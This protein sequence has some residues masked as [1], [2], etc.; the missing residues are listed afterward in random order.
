MEGLSLK[1]SPFHDTEAQSPHAEKTPPVPFNFVGSRH[2]SLIPL[3][4]VTSVVSSE[5][6]GRVLPWI[7]V[8]S[9]VTR[10][11]VEGSSICANP[12]IYDHGACATMLP[13]R[14]PMA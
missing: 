9:A 13:V 10:E 14:S 7:H 12:A 3:G 6:M 4:V 8:A 11:L 2:S 1:V 5:S